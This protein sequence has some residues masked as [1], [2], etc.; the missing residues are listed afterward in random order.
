MAFY[1]SHHTSS[2]L[3]SPSSYSASL[4]R[5]AAAGSCSGSL[6]HGHLALV[7]R[8]SPIAA[9]AVVTH[10]HTHALLRRR[11]WR[12]FG[13]HLTSSYGQLGTRTRA[14]DRPTNRLRRTGTARAAT[15]LTQPATAWRENSLP[16]LGAKNKTSKG[17]FFSPPL[18]RIPAIFFT[19]FN[20]CRIFLP[21]IIL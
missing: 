21:K 11:R 10:A 13:S 5:S 16:Q 6:R 3:C 20:I 7:R 14:T 15:I 12:R 2:S 1:H 17:I 4:V 18:I 8:S 19:I 9:A